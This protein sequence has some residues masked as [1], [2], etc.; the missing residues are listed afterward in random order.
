MTIEDPR[1][2]FVLERNDGK[3][4]IILKL[5]ET[6]SAISRLSEIRN[7][8][9][10]TFPE[11]LSVFI[12]A[13]NE[14]SQATA[15]VR[16]ELVRVDH[17]SNLLRA[18]LL[19]EEVP[20]IIEE[21]KLKNTQDVCN[22]ILLLNSEYASLVYSY[23]VLRSALEILDAKSKTIRDAQFAIRDVAQLNFDKAFKKST[24]EG[25][26]QGEF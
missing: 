8:N 1:D 12:N 19:I 3:Q 25:R 5:T 6:N 15:V 9:T 13:N 4:P 18:K 17:R 21:R 11:L 22:S 16:Q 26:Y 14:L 2:S 20:L 10:A 7:V 24:L 23:E